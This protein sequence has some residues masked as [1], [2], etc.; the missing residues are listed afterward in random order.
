MHH[1]NRII[2]RRVLQV[3]QMIAIRTNSEPLFRQSAQCED[4]TRLIRQHH[5]AL[6]IQDQDP[7]AFIVASSAGV[8]IIPQ[9]K[10]SGVLTPSLSDYSP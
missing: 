10:L 9:H 4:V 6:R 5:R 8:E 2:S 3:P 7:F 1:L